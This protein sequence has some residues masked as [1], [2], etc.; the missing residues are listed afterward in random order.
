M[1]TSLAQG[2]ISNACLSRLGLM[3]TVIDFAANPLSADLVVKALNLPAGV[4][5]LKVG[6]R[7]L[8]VEAGK[9]VSVG[10]SASGTTYLT[11]QSMATLTDAADAL[12]ACGKYY[13]A[14]DYIVLTLSAAMSA[15][16]VQV[17]ALVSLTA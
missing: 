17:W 16:K 7:V 1:I 5:V 13:A 11:T 15:G 14:A 4:H 10:D 9:T 8:A 6:A 2:G 12:T 3:S